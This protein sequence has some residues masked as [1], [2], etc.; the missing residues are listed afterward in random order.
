MLAKTHL[1]VRSGECVC[2]EDPVFAETI[3][4]DQC[5]RSCYDVGDEGAIKFLECGGPNAY[6]LY[7]LEAEKVKRGG[8]CLAVSCG[9]SVQEF[10][11]SSN[12]SESY[13]GA[14]V[15]KE[16]LGCFQD[17]QNRTLSGISRRGDFTLTVGSCRKFCTDYQFYG[18]EFGGDC[19]CGNFFTSFIKKPERECN[20]K[21]SG[22]ES[23]SCGGADRI[24]IYS[25]LNYETEIKTNWTSSMQICKTR[26]PSSYLIGNVSLTDSTLACKQLQRKQRGFTWL[27]IAKEVYTGYDRGVAV[28]IHEN[29]TFHQCQKCNQT[30]C[31][32]VNCFEK[33]DYL[34]CEKGSGFEIPQRRVKS[35]L[36]NIVS[37]LF[38]QLCFKDLQSKK[39]LVQ[40]LLLPF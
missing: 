29:E 38:V 10:S 1:L 25:N 40:Y 24:N 36:L 4:S 6:T 5:N 34:I 7:T 32:F 18:V 37:D 31:E 22:N 26:Y 9:G 17:Q 20:I 21:C 8:S 14:C 11:Y 13:F 30:T 23:Q 2:F 39:M 33:L 27:S 19:F 3:S 12:C 35:K 15:Y 28:D 16:Y